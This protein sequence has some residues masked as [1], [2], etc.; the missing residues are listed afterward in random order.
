MLRHLLGLSLVALV[1]VAPGRGQDAKKD[2][3]KS[4]PKKGVYLTPEDGGTDYSLQGEYAGTVGAEKWAAQVVAKGDGKFEVYFLAGGLPGAGWDA[5]TRT[6]ADAKTA[7]GKTIFDAD[8]WKGT[9]GPGKLAGTK[10]AVAFAFAKVE[11]TSPRAGAKPPEG[12]VVLFDG[13]KV[14]EWKNGKIVEE[15]HLYCGTTALKKYL[16]A[17]LHL[18][19]RTPFQPKASGQG[20]GNS[21]IKFNGDEIQV[22][23]SFGLDGKVNEC[24]AWYNKR[25]PDVNLC[26]PPLVWQTYDVT[27][28]P[29]EDGKLLATVEH[30]G[31]VVHDKHPLA[32]KADAPLGILLQDHRNPV[33]YRN[34]W[35]V[36]RK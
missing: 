25:K 22:L 11:R 27:F 4:D 23:D 36:E 8:G 31:V 9:L 13:A 17:K 20:R 15:K 7:E 33:V 35:L 28:T 12:A 18:E 5:K 16:I 29:T 24:G 32:T 6:R 26:L 19:F 1:C 34:I 14:D 30:N 2:D 10:D 3:L 21:G